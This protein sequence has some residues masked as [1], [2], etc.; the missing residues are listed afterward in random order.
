MT[1]RIDCFLRDQCP[2]AKDGCIWCFARWLD[3]LPLLP[4]GVPPQS[5]LQTMVTG[6]PSDG[7]IHR[8]SKRR[9]CDQL[10]I[11]RKHACDC[12]PAVGVEISPQV[13]RCW[14]CADFQTA[15]VTP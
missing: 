13:L 5:D 2:V 14:D 11:C 6:E 7:C 10:W 1:E 9:C 3:V 12:T 4:G 8:G 15:E